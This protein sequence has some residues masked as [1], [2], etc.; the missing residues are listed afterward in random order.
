MFTKVFTEQDEYPIN[1][2]SIH[3]TQSQKQK[4]QCLIS[5][6]AR[7]DRKTFLCEE[8]WKI[9]RPCPGHFGG[10]PGAKVSSDC[11]A[12]RSGHTPRSAGI[13]ARNAAKV[14]ELGIR[15]DNRVPPTGSLQVFSTFGPESISVALHS[16]LRL[17][18]SKRN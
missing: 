3:V 2:S 18:G 14:L 7:S 13:P 6:E 15:A 8:K 12:L 5:I 11:Q 1:L 10:P 4:T 16:S 17:Y 9:W